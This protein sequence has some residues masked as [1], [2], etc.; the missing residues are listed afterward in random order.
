MVYRIDIQHF[1]THAV[2]HFTVE[3]L[4]HFQYVIISARVKNGMRAANVA[5]KN[6]LYP[7]PEIVTAYAEYQD[8]KILEKMYMD[9]LR[10]KKTDTGNNPYANCIYE[11]IVKLL[12]KHFDIVILCDKSENDYIDILCKYLKEDFEIDVIDLNELFTKGRVGSIYIDRKV[13]WDKAV[14]VRRSTLRETIKSLESSRDG[15]IRLL[16]MMDKKSKV[17]K[18]KELGITVNESDMKNLDKLL[19]DEWVENDNDEDE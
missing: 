3:E 6:E 19:M 12:I 14:D 2:D 9:M 18:L 10:P 15:K 7:S 1:L 5:K 11:T 4:T 16:G 8:K 13:I 17:K